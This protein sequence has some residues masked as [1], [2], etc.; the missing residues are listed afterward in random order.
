M[1][2]TIPSLADPS[3]V[4]GAAAGTHVMSVIVQS[5]P[6]ALRDGTWDEA[7][8]DAFGDL[9]VRTLDGI[10]AGACRGWSPRGRC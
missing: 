3:L 4:D 6:Y 2:A 8:R 1:E 9:V 7:A 5:A 10:R